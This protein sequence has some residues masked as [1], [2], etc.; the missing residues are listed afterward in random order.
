MK[1]FRDWTFKWWEV[2]ILKLALLT[3]GILLGFYFGEF[4]KG[5]MIVFMVILVISM[6]YFIIFRIKE[7]FEDN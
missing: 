6:L 1:L 4:L 5:W 3:L 2:G 7:V